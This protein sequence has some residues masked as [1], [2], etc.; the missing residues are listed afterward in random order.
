M[1]SPQGE[2]RVQIADPAQRHDLIV[3][4]ERARLLDES[5]VIRLRTRAD[6]LLGAWVATG[7]DVLAGRVVEGTVRPADL[8]CAA[9]QLAA[10]LR[11]ADPSGSVDP[12]Y[13]MDS[14]W[15]GALPAETGFV[16]L[17]DVPATVLA[18]LARSG[19]DLSREQGAH[20]PPA[21]LLEQEVLHVS[22]DAGEV[23]IP[24]RCALAL[25]AM[26]F[27]P[28]EPDAGEVVRVRISPAWL[29]I[30]ARYGSVFR[31]RGGAALLL[32]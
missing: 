19:A 18:Q 8:T 5:A 6:A 16:H 13:P 9:D 26:R 14:A 28:D 31:R 29:R 30:D 20:G 27:L 1:T 15:R 11:T 4:A 7:F 32:R 21:S 10:A 3:L 24:M 17:D 2:R 25:A 12:G 23:G 22:G